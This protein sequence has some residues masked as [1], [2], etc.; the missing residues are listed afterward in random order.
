MAVYKHAEN[1]AALR[2]LRIMA[3]FTTIKSV[4]E[5]TKTNYRTWQ[6]WELGIT[7][8]YEVVF[9]YLELLIEVRNKGKVQEIGIEEFGHSKE[10]MEGL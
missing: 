6:N 4:C 8:P 2:E 5:Y 10:Y 3:G 1:G 7:V 9:L